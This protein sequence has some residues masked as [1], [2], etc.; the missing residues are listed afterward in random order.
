MVGAITAFPSSDF[1]VSFSTNHAF[2]KKQLICCWISWCCEFYPEAG[3]EEPRWVDFGQRGTQGCAVAGAG[4]CLQ[5]TVR[6]RWRCRWCTASHWPCPG[7]SGWTPLCSAAPPGPVSPPGTWTGG[8]LWHCL[9]SWCTCDSG[10]KDHRWW[11]SSSCGKSRLQCPK[12]INVSCEKAFRDGSQLKLWTDLH[13]SQRDVSSA[14][15]EKT[16]GNTIKLLSA[17]SQNLQTVLG[18]DYEQK[19]VRKSCQPASPADTKL[20]WKLSTYTRFVYS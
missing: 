2:G 10:H 3:G 1:Y 16:W 9:R 18:L 4:Q 11:Q 14:S 15:Q 5:W 19:N 20:L 8:Q 13:T 12:S 17:V 6:R 7:S